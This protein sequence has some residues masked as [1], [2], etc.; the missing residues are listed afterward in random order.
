[1]KLDEGSDSIKSLMGSLCSILLTI[2]LFTYAYQ[3]MDVLIGR[4]D[5]DVLQ[6]TNEMYFPDDDEF[7][8]THGFRVAIAFT[9][10]RLKQQWEL[11]PTYASL[12]LKSF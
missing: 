7:S 4:K 8:A 11:D 9:S 3:K 10:G 2:V 6:T 1:M 12:E 5:I